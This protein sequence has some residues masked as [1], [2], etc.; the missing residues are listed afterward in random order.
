MV[1]REC[2]SDLIPLP[3]FQL[4]F[5]RECDVAEAARVSAVVQNH[6][7][8]AQVEGYRQLPFNPE[9]SDS[10]PP[11]VNSELEEEGE[12]FWLHQGADLAAIHDKVVR[13]RSLCSI[14]F[15]IVVI[16]LHMIVEVWDV[17]DG[18]RQ[19]LPAS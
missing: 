7:R 15:V 2:Q 9:Q 11:V 12:S 19:I 6:L 5:Q 10:K 16:V 1:T 4:L 13:G 17:R 14:F 8:V 18:L 3:N